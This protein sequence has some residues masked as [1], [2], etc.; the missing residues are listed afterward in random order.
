MPN[1]ICKT[2]ITAHCSINING[3]PNT[4]LFF[5]VLWWHIHM[6]RYIPTLPPNIAI[7]NSVASLTLLLPDFALILSKI[8][9]MAAIKE[10]TTKYTKKIIPK[11]INITP[12]FRIW[13]LLFHRYY[14]IIIYVFQQTLYL[15]KVFFW[16]AIL[17]LKE[18]PFY[19]LLLPFQLYIPLLLLF[20][21]FL[22]GTTVLSWVVAFLRK[23]SRHIPTFQAIIVQILTQQAVLIALIQVILYRLI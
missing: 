12:L 16:R 23:M 3:T 1:S 13:P 19:L 10:T 15:R 2:Y 11:S 14:N 6:A 7:Q 8:T 22:L 9:I 18:Q 17:S 20:V 5:C 21:P 4:N